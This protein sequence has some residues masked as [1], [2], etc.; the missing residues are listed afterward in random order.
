MED[1]QGREAGW[2]SS[3]WTGA[4]GMNELISM[5][6]WSACLLYIKIATASTQ[7]TSVWN[8]SSHV[9]FQ[10]VSLCMLIS[11]AFLDMPHLKPSKSSVYISVDVTSRPPVGSGSGFVRETKKVAKLLGHVWTV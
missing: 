8:H 7:N 11:C 10:K 6:C 2:E 5:E 9:L 3:L 4:D 1:K